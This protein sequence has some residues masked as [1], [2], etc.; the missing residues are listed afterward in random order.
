MTTPALPPSDQ[1]LGHPEWVILGVKQWNGNGYAVVA[2]KELSRA[3]L[4]VLIETP[5][6]VQYGPLLYRGADR[7]RGVDLTVRMK[8]YVMTWGATYADALAN[9]MRF[10]APDDDAPALASPAP[11][12]IEG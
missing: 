6:V 10:W 5:P 1:E 4:T 9:L 3:E 11:P 12:A 7:V 8:N 2:S